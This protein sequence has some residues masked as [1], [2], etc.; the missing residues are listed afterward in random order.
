[1]AT[2]PVSFLLTTY[3]HGPFVEEAVRSVLAQDWDEPMLV[4]IS[5]DC[6][7][8]DTWD[9]IQAVVAAYTG[10]FEISLHRNAKNLGPLTHMKEALG[11]CQGPIIVR[12]HGDDI[13]L[14]HRV[15]R[16]VSVFRQKGALLVSSNAEEMSEEGE[17]LKLILPKGADLHMT[18][19]TVAQAGWTWHMLG[20][21]YSFARK[22]IETWGW[23][24][25]TYLSSGGDHVLPFRAALQGGFHY[26]G[27]PLL[28]WR[29]HAGQQTRQLA[30]P[31]CGELIY[32]SLHAL[33]GLAPAMQRLR[34]LRRAVGNPV[35]EQ[36]RPI[37]GA[38]LQRILSTL[39]EFTEMESTLR[40]QGLRL[41]WVTK[42]S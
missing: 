3:N 13:Q 39:T 34:D 37:E 23:L 17:T 21:T 32:N 24:D 7:T 35:P 18:V 33:P 14:P 30:N 5:D 22:Y 2:P 10:P 25:P 31:E 26:V 27:E 15:T 41:D 28:R 16:V 8:D 4:H 19:G 36:A 9:K 42:S 29:R 20:A 1:M 12:G 38:L 40:R 11:R 6:S